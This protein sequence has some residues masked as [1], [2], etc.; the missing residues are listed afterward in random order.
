MIE[1]TGLMIIKNL[2]IL[3]VGLALCF[4]II[5]IGMIVASPISGAAP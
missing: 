2:V 5:F 1:D 4:L 3:A